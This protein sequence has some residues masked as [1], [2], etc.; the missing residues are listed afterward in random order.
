MTRLAARGYTQIRHIL[1]QLPDA[2]KPRASTVARALSQ[3]KHRA[4]LLYIL[5]LTC[6]PWLKDRREPLEAEVWVR[7][8][9]SNCGPTW[10]TSTLSRAWADLVDLGVVE[11]VRE[12]R[13]V[14]VKR[15]HSIR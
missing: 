10:S 5:L 9:Q 1:V 13:L 4:L 7:A 14:R 2:D 15:R 3:R 11:K 8:L 6:W 12:G